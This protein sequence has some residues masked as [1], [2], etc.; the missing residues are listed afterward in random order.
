MKREIIIAGVLLVAGILTGMTIDSIA[1]YRGKIGSRSVEAATL[2]SEHN[3]K[4]RITRG[5][6]WMM[7]V[8]DSQGDVGSECSIALDSNGFPHI[9]YFDQ[10]WSQLEYAYYNGNQWVKDTVDNGAG[11]STSIELDSNDHPHISYCDPIDAADAQLKYAYHDGTQWN[12][13]IVDS[14]PRV[15]WYTSLELDSG[16]R[17]HISYHDKD[18]NDLK[19]AYYNGAAWVNQ[20]VDTPDTVGVQSSMKLNSTEKPHI[21]HWDYTNGDLRHSYYDGSQWHSETVD[22]NGEVGAG[23]SIGTDSNDFIHIS[24]FDDTNGNLKY[25]FNDGNGWQTDTIDT[26]GEIGRGTSIAIDTNDGVHICYQEGTN[27][28]FKYAFNNGSGW[29]IEVIDAGNAGKFNSIVLDDNDQPHCCY[30]LWGTFGDDLKYATIDNAPPEVLADGSPTTATTG[31][32]YEFNVSAAD[33]VGLE[34][35]HAKWTHELDGGNESLALMGDYWRGWIFTGDYIEPMS[36]VI[37]VK[38]K[39]NLFHISTETFVTVTDNDEPDLSDDHTPSMFI[40]NI[41]FT[42]NITATD[43]VGIENVSVYYEHGDVSLNVS[44]AE[45]GDYWQH[46]LTPEEN[47]GDLL[48]RVFIEDTSGNLYSGDWN[49]VTELDADAPVF[50]GEHTTGEPQTGEI[51]NITVEFQDNDTVERIYLNY[52]FDGA[53]YDSAL[54]GNINNDMWSKEIRISNSATELDYYFVAKD[55]T[56]NQRDTRNLHGEVSLAVKDVIQPS[57]RAGNDVTI[58]VGEEVKFDGRQSTDNIEIVNHTWKFYYDGIPHTLYGPTAASFFEIAGNYTVTL[59]VSDS[60]GNVGTDDMKIE[61]HEVFVDKP[62]ANAGGDRTIDEGQ[63]VYLNATGNDPLLELNYTWTFVYNG[64]MVTMKGKEVNFTF[65]DVG[66]YTIVLMVSDMEGGWSDDNFTVTVRDIKA[67]LANA[68]KDRT[69]ELHEKLTFDASRSSD[70]VGITNYTW[71]FVYNG[72][73][74]TLYGA[75]VDFT[76]D[77]PGNYTINLTI[78][79]AA[80]YSA[81][82]TTRIVVRPVAG[83]DDASED[84]DTDD[85]IPTEKKESFPLW[86]IIAIIVTIIALVVILLVVIISKRK[87]PEPFVD[88]EEEERAIPKTMPEDAPIEYEDTEPTMMESDRIQSPLSDRY[89]A[90]SSAAS[91]VDYDTPACPKC[92][93]SSTYYPEYE[94]YWCETCRDYVYQQDESEDIYD[95]DWD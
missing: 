27:D 78:T 45:T 90:P 53:N 43:N 54:M 75:K 80:G 4:Y 44:L 89:E 20:T 87:R 91:H 72:S 79:D 64:S 88:E 5:N 6:N 71:T 95:L 14:E 34:S 9:S 32:L 93:G 61:V 30:S 51:F 15:G 36:Y 10:S 16:G 47:E 67:P 55:A 58:F 41:D 65:V 35:V 12:L 1:F 69:I 84:D 19:Y 81:N 63:T 21:A 33:N 42:F 94:S 49:T 50:V 22:S 73:K 2:H 13:E 48:Y 24:Y 70:N 52:S 57:A 74:T 18:K 25:A 83:D 39:A 68:G 62:V 28:Q 86:G 56:G 92:G 11:Y 17:P 8:V 26:L 77:V 3:D 38:D 7:Q 31:D 60:A 82:D 37:Y 23:P 29:Q 76:F 40:P 46:T 59:T 66:V 85:E